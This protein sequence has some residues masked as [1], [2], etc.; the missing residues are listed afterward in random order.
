MNLDNR[1]VVLPPL[2]T[3]QDQLLAHAL[4]IDGRAPFRRIAEV[5]GVS[6]QTVARRYSRLRS[7]GTLRVV[8]LTDPLRLG[9][10]PWFVRVRCAPSAAGAI[11]EALARRPDTAWVSLTSGGTEIACLVRPRTTGGGDTLLL[12]KLPRTPQVAEVS[13]HCVLHVFF[14]QDLSLLTKSGPLTAAQVAALR[15]ANAPDNLLSDPA[16]AYP[17]D[18]ADHRL[19]DVL[20][21]DGRAAVG[22]LAAATGRPPTTVRRRM[23]EL[24]EAGVLY[25]DVDFAPRVLQRNFRAALWLNVVPS[26]IEAVGGTLASHPEVSFAAATT[27]DFNVYASVTTPDAGAFYRYLTGPVAALPGILGTSTAPIHRAFKCAGPL[28]RR[29][30]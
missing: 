29:D 15:P 10:V 3:E 23:A 22:E 27:G 30:R 25:F 1:R 24:R 5:L 9:E 4:Q 14:G 16:P 12:E 20:A 17:L 18:E 2:D 28:E 26:D 21:R 8:G 11:G 19:L 7:A 13:G 6:D